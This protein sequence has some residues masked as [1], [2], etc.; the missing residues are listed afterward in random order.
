VQEQEGVIQQQQQRID[1][2]TKQVKELREL[3]LAATKK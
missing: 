2:L 3:I 1:D